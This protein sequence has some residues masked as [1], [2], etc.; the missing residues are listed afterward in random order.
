[1]SRPKDLPRQEWEIR[2]GKCNWEI[3]HGDP[4]TRCQR[5][6]S[7]IVYDLSGKR[8]GKLCYEHSNEYYQLILGV[9]GFVTGKFV[10]SN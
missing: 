1:M 5:L 3:K 9:N 2:K 4:R 8:N 6:P 7:E 10:S